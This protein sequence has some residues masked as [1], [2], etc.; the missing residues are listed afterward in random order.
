LPT[1]VEYIHRDNIVEKPFYVDKIVER[2]VFVPVDKIVEVPVERVVER[3]IE[4]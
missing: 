1:E 4:Q 3:P 2:E